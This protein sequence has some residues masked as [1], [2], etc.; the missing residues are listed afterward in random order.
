MLR[1]LSSNIS[2]TITGSKPKMASAVNMTDMKT[3]H[4]VEEASNSTLF[5]SG[6]PHYVKEQDLVKHFSSFGDIAELIYTIKECKHISIKAYIV[7][8]KKYYL[9]TSI[10]I[11]MAYTNMIDFY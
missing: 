11:H 1:N 7:T 5:C 8:I 10:F 4:R 9:I 3:R 2:N 6:I